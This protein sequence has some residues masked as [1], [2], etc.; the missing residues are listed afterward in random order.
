[1]AGIQRIEVG[2]SFDTTGSMYACLMSV[3]RKIRDAIHDL[4]YR[5]QIFV[6]ASSHMVITVIGIPRT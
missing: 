4:F 2:I 6:L 1:M 3:R 5:V